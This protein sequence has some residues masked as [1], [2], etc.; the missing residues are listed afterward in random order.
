VGHALRTKGVLA[1]ARA[2]AAI[3]QAES[4]KAA[5]VAT[6]PATN[7]RA[8]RLSPALAMARAASA[9]AAPSSA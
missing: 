1:A 2:E 3:S 9:A 5:S 7:Q 4:L 6:A 8:M